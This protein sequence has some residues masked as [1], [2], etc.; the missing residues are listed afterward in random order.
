M[1]DTVFLCRRLLCMKRILQLWIIV[2]L[3]NSCHS[4]LPSGN[5][6]K[7]IDIQGHRG[8][9][10]LMPENT[11]PAMIRALQL[12]V[13]TLEMD[14]V[15]TKDRQVILSHEPYFGWEISTTPEGKTFSSREEKD[16]NIYRMNYDEIKKWDVGK[17]PHPRFPRQEKLEIYKPLLQELIDSI[18]HY[19]S[20]AHL[21]PVDYNIETKCSPA[22]D[23]LY[24]PGPE[25]FVDLLISVIRNKGIEK[26]VV[27]QSFD[28][29]T[30]QIVQKKYPGI[31]TALLIEGFNRRSPEE[32]VKE[33]GFI[34]NIY[35]PEFT[36]VNAQLVQFCK[37]KNILL[38]PWT[39]N[40]RESI[41]RL[42]QLGVNGIITDFPDLFPLK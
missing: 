34:P 22:T 14:A 18:E 25:E 1:Y 7:K 30:L 39:V 31:K 32:N 13:T 26:R 10:G 35:S 3:V 9:R 21:T 33:L 28:I 17:R 37:T 41:D 8:C 27:I 2:I 6:M 5:S 20:Q 42:L 23:D 4:K 11:V 36:L 16:F 15:I 29:R 19:I 38:V 12:G 40:D 24:H